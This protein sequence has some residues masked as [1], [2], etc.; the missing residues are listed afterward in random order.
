MNHKDL[1]HKY[2]VFK[3][4]YKLKN[5]EGLPI[6]NCDVGS[7][8]DLIA[9]RIINFIS[10]KAKPRYIDE[11]RPED[12]VSYEVSDKRLTCLALSI[13]I[14][15]SIASFLCLIFILNVSVHQP[16]VLAAQYGEDKDKLGFP[17]S[18]VL[19][20]EKQGDGSLL[21]F[22]QINQSFFE[23]GWK[24]KVPGGKSNIHSYILFE[25]L[26]QVYV[27]YSNMNKKMTILQTLAI[28]NFTDFT[29]P[30]SELRQEFL[31]G[32]SLRLG[33]FVMV[34][35]VFVF[36]CIASIIFSNVIPYE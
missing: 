34:C 9:D 19:L 35:I 17:K 1:M 33:T 21:V 29:I 25:D 30:R 36:L 15:S 3:D 26:G 31:G 2:N 13:A 7:K 32:Y 24:F 14:L 16:K 22:R 4:P 12:F 20:M 5:V 23:Y 27:A 6:E 10:V 8:W 28:R 11:D 18:H